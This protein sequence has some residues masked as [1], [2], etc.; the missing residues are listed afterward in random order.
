MEKS[1]WPDLTDDGDFDDLSLA[2]EQS[3]VY[4]QQLPPE[5]QFSFGEDSYSL[6]DMVQS[7]EILGEFLQ[8]NPNF[9][10]FKRFLQENFQLY[11]SLGVG[12]D[13]TVTFSA[14]C[15]YTIPARLKPDAEF[16]YP[17]YARPPGLVDVHAE[18][19]DS[20]RKGERM[21]GRV[22]GKDLVPYFTRK[23]IDSDK[24][25][26]G[27]GLEVAWSKSLLD[28][29]FLQ[30]QGSGWLEAPGTTET[31]HIRYAGDNGLPYRSVGLHLIESGAIPKS[32]FNK[33]KMIE[34]FNRQTEE[35][36]HDILNY[37][38]R[39]IFFEVVSATHSSR[40][41]LLVPLTPCRSIATDPKVYPRAALAWIKTLRPKIDGKGNVSGQEPM[42]RFVLN[43]DEGGAIQG[44]GR[45]D[46]FAGH[47]WKAQ[48]MAESLWFKGDLYFLVQKR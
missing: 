20:K 3:L 19:F 44:P 27:K 23:E 16:R 7:L 40:G 9:G 33:A 31:Y 12:S 32:E 2:L 43:Q 37:N 17:L 5:T 45:V 13:N 28:I 42:M 39:Y 41:S 26:E 47:D 8:G 4:C 36:Q 21:A 48:K 6:Q 25:L 15:S 11:R 14:Y 24:I 34:Y 35:R 46:Y 29:L 10:E 38:P 22:E 1:Q 30:I 18:N